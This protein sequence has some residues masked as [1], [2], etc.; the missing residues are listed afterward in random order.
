MSTELA[1]RNTPVAKPPERSPAAKFRDVATNIAGSLLREWVGPER[2]SEAIG[3][4]SAALSASAA[5]ARD[6]SDFY[7]CTPASIATCVA[8]SALTGLMPG[9]GSSAL[10]Y[11]VPQRPRANEAPQLQYSLSHR[12]LNALARRCGQT[13]V[14]VPIGFDDMIEVSE[15]GEVRVISR[16][17]DKPPTEWDELRGVVV[18]VKELATGN[19]I[20]RGWVPRI[21]IEKRRTMSRSWSGKGREY[22]PWTKWP[23][24][25]AIKTAMH[26]AIGRGWCVIDDT[27]ASRALSADMAGDV[28]LIPNGQQT[29][30]TNGRAASS[31]L[32]ERLSA[33]AAHDAAEGS[34]D[35]PTATEAAS[36]ATDRAETTP[37][38]ETPVVPAA[39]DTQPAASQSPPAGTIPESE[40]IDENTYLDMLEGCDSLAAVDKL[41]FDFC[42]PERMEAGV[43]ERCVVG[44]RKR[45]DQIRV[46]AQEKKAGTPKP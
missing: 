11:V 18:L 17:I 46:A 3:R 6:P 34:Q 25:Q 40:L 22:S 12:G 24:E 21:L 33:K 36:S 19:V 28:E 14:A 8:I 45:K 1:E 10:A 41:S 31:D 32:N 42:N 29:R 38:V 13:M 9:T 43:R 7:A 5:S 15:D 30:L 26:Y 44:N 39:S 2:A 23:V 37:S 35:E 4:I 27:A 16:D 20:V